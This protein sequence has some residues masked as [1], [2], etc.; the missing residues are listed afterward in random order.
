MGEGNSYD[1]GARM[2]DP[3]VGRW[4][5]RDP[6]VQPYESPYSYVANNPILFIDNDGEDNIIYLVLLPSAREKLGKKGIASIKKEMQQRLKDLGLHTEIKIFDDGGSKFDS[7][8]LDNSD[9]FVVLGSLNEI[10][11]EVKGSPRYADLNDKSE[12]SS[13]IDSFQGSNDY[14]T[15][16]NPENS[17]Q[18]TSEDERKSGKIEFAS[19][20]LVDINVTEEIT[21]KYNLQTT[22][23]S[24]FSYFA[25]HGLGHDS[26]VGYLNADYGK[27]SRSVGRTKNREIDAMKTIEDVFNK[28]NNNSFIKALRKRLNDQKGVT[29]TDNYERNKKDRAARAGKS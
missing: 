6:I 13:T 3:R 12:G 1:F 9:S 16:H 19:G 8:N 25:I 17:A 27:I 14:G 24:S 11:K 15:Y 29:P 22:K 18:K 28:T 10:K 23:E 20:V 26:R 5:K 21:A 7:R 2:L 4:F